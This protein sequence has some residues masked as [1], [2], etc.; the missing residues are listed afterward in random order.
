[1]GNMWV[2]SQEAVSD[3]RLCVTTDYVKL[4]YSHGATGVATATRLC[5]GTVPAGSLITRFLVR[6]V[7]AFNAASNDYL[8]IGTG[9]DDDL[10]INDGD[11]SGGT[12]ATTPCI[13]EYTGAASGYLAT[14]L[15]Y[16]VTEDTPIYA[17]YVYSGTAPTTGEAQ[18]AMEYVAWAENGDVKT[19]V[20]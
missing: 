16:L 8:T 9:S 17:T 10:F 11:L 20:G 12:F 6:L 19:K 14:G 2:D 3:N 18:I 5:I 4:L 13:S 7:T 15:P 1:M